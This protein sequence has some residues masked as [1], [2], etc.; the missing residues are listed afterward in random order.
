MTMQESYQRETILVELTNKR[1]NLEDGSRIIVATFWLSLTLQH[2]LTQEQ[3]D[4][5]LASLSI[6]KYGAW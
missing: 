3:A 5:T 4:A 1:M 6:S 2:V